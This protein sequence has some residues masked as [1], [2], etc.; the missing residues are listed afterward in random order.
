MPHGVDDRAG[1]AEQKA[2]SEGE[3]RPRN[4]SSA[5]PFEGEAEQGHDGHAERTDG[6]EVSPIDLANGVG[7]GAW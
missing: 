3:E 2:G 7:S 1:Y 6:D 4:P 5:K